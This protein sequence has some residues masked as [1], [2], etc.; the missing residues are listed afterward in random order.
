MQP[1]TSGKQRFDDPPRRQVIG[2]NSRDFR[3]PQ[4]ADF[5]GSL[6]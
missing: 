5:A 4:A 1:E 2:G 6:Q 3:T